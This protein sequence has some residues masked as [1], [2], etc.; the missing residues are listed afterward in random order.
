[1]R[2]QLQDRQKVGDKSPFF[3]IAVILSPSPV[4]LSVAKDPIRIREFVLSRGDSYFN[5]ILL[6]FSLSSNLTI[7]V[8]FSHPLLR[9]HLT[10]FVII[11]YIANSS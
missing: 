8:T 3:F 10:L 2:S 11:K 5:S 9:R 1:M 7:I 4:I 6:D